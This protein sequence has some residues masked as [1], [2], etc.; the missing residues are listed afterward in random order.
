M[1]GSKVWLP[2]ACRPSRHAAIVPRGMRRVRL[3]LRRCRLALIAL[4]P[5]LAAGCL[6]HEVVVRVNGDG[7]G[8]IVERVVMSHEFIEMFKQMSAPGKPFQLRTAEQLRQDASNYGEGVRLHSG[9]NIETQFGRGYEAKYVFD[10]VTRLRIGQNPGDRMPG[11]SS[12]GAGVDGSTGKFTTFSLRR[13]RQ[14]ELV[15]HWPVD[16]PSVD[17]GEEPAASVENGGADAVGPTTEEERAA[18]EM[19]TAAFK[20]MRMA[21]H[22]EVMGEIVETNATHRD[23][24]RVTLVEI[25]FAELLS[26]EDALLQMAQQKPESVADLKEMM[27]LIPGLKLEIEP[28]VAIR[29]R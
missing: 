28:E 21:V 3:S 26:S 18:L 12:E 15:V 11:E 22:V 27:T 25:S 10:D 13:D 4:L 5:L 14:S 24:S 8:T 16:E 23:G 17:A 29:F 7:S 2:R 6:Q 1:P 19:M 20:G 9:K